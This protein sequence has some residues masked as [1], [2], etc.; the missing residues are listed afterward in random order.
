MP[1]CVEKELFIYSM[2]LVDEIYLIDQLNRFTIPDAPLQLGNLPDIVRVMI[3]FKVMN[4][5]HL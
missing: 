5:I 3:M 4:L 1:T 2:H